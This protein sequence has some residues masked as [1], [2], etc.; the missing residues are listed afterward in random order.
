MRDIVKARSRLQFD[1]KVI[2]DFVPDPTIDPRLDV[3]VSRDQ[4]IG[5]V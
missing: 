4:P 5:I 1:L 3:L 2:V